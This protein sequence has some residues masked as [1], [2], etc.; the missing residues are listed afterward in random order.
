MNKNEHEISEIEKIF[1]EN[2]TSKQS[3]H[4]EF[5]LKLLFVVGSVM[6]GYGF[7]LTKIE[8]EFCNRNI[9]LFMFIFTD[10]VLLLFF[11]IVYDDGFSF[12]RD[13]LV[14]YRLLRKYNL[15]VESKL[16]ETDFNKIFPSYYN[17]TKKFVKN[18]DSIKIKGI[19]IF[20]LPM[21]HNTI[22]FTI[23]I[24]H[25]LVYITTINLLPE[26]NNY[27]FWLFLVITS[28][29]YILIIIR[30]NFSIKNLYKNEVIRV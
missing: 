30:R 9:I 17:P 8:T 22:A 27:S 10:L 11:K 4:V 7:I 29:I 28:I 18:N 16:D 23:Y 3:T 14:V 1:Y 6:G 26:W 5:L 2:F 20:L 25:F 15:I 13:Q 12:R 24:F 21:F 19:I